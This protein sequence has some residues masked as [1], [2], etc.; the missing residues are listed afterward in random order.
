MVIGRTQPS[1]GAVSLGITENMFVSPGDH[2]AY[3]W[4]SEVDFA[5]GVRFLESG[6]REGDHCVVFGYD[7][8]NEK[9]LALLRSSAVP[10]DDLLRDGRLAVLGSGA[11]GDATLD[12]IGGTFG[13]LLERGARR[14]RLLGNIGWGR[15]GWPSER[16]ILAFESRVTGA[17]ANLPCVVVCMYDVR[18]LPGRVILHGALETHPLTFCRNVVRENPGYVPIDEFLQT[19]P[20]G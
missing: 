17:V 11:T 15:E 7:E 18:S 8:A 6:I 12:E 2:I 10:V 16:E 20:V 1:K 5:R 4:E 9:V 3:F 13:R 14:L 19:L